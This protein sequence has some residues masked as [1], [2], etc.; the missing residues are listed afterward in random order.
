MWSI[1][2]VTL[3]ILLAISVGILFLDRNL[4]RDVVA[5]SNEDV[6]ETSTATVFPGV[7]SYSNCSTGNTGES[8][9]VYVKDTVPSSRSILNH[10]DWFQGKLWKGS[11]MTVE[12]VCYS[13]GR[14]W[15]KSVPKSTRQPKFSYLAH[16]Q[17]G[18]SVGYPA[19]INVRP[20]TD[21]VKNLTCPYSPLPNHLVLHALYNEML[22]EF[23]ARNLVG[24]NHVL[25]QEDNLKQLL[26]S[27]QV[28]LQLWNLDRGLLDSHHAFM[29]PFLT[30]QLL[31]F[32][33]LLHSS[34]CSCVER[35][36]LCGHEFKTDTDRDEI[37]VKQGIGMLPALYKGPGIKGDDPALYKDAQAKLRQTVILGNPIMQ[38]DIAT[39]RRQLLES[40][41]VKDSFDDWK[42]LG[43]AVSMAGTILALDTA[44]NDLTLTALMPATNGKKKVDQHRESAP[45]LR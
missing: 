45:D 2:E 11:C 35:L 28:Y 7:R 5:F 9:V 31:D 14:W 24:L 27:T 25:S 30:H 36:I 43:L 23:Y 44:N 8:R 13:T 6:F 39:Y 3:F 15:Y 1:K 38:E 33:E 29:A 18:S 17:P 41:G 42:I 16:K 37:L 32:R 19:E 21:Q 40:K 12:N 20:A 26:E 22:G 10:T 4:F 34:A